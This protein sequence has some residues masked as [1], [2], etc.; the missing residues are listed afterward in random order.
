MAKF[1]IAAIVIIVFPST[2]LGIKFL[3]EKCS[4]KDKHH[5]DSEEHQLGSGSQHENFEAVGEDSKL[6]IEKHDVETNE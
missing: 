4:K 2:L 5:E 6:L 3:Y 1:G